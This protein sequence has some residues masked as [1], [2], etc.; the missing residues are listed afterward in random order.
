VMTDKKLTTLK[1]HLN[2]NQ[3]HIVVLSHLEINLMKLGK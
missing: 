3:S 2:L 1:L